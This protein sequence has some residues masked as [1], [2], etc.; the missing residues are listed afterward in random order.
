MELLKPCYKCGQSPVAGP[1][2]VD[3]AVPQWVIACPNCGETT[4]GFAAIEAAAVFW[5]DRPDG[6][7]SLGDPSLDEDEDKAA[8]GDRV[9]EGLLPA[10]A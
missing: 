7:P 6:G 4:A 9:S 2:A 5:N 10:P 8:T 1:A 3:A